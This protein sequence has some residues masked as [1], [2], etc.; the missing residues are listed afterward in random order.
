[1]KTKAEFTEQPRKQ[2]RAIVCESLKN[3]PY[4]I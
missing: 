1:M 2:A 4:S 3:C